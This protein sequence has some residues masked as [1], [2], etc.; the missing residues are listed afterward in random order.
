M[1]DTNITRAE[2]RERSSLVRV[3]RYDVH[4]DLSDARTAGSATFPSTSRVSFTAEPGASTWIDI[5]APSVRRAALNGVE[6]DPS[7]FTGT[8]LPLPALAADNEL[9][10]E[11]DCAYM[12]TGEGLHRFVDPVDGS[13]YLYSQFEVADARRMYACFDQPDLKGEFALTVTA[14]RG[15]QV[16]SNAPTP[17]PVDAGDDT[18]RW[19]FD[20]TPRLSPY[21][22][23]L[24]AGPYHVVRDEYVGPH[25]TY[26]LGVFCR[27]SLAQYLD[28]DEVLT[29]TKQGFEFFE[30]A[31]A[32]PYPFA[33][34]DQLFVPEFN[35]GAM[36]NAACVTI[37]EDYVFR[38]RVTHYSYEQRANTVLHEL[39]HMWFG[40]LVTMTWWDDLWLNESFAEW[41]AHYSSVGA[42][43]YRDAWTTFL[44]QRKGWAYKQ[45]QLSSTHPIAA[46]M[47]DLEA[48]EVNFDG[49][50]YAQGASALRQLVAWVGEKEFLE[51]LTAYFTRHAWGNTQLHDLLA[52]L[53]LSSGRDLSGWSSA[54]LETSGVNLLRPE[55]EVAADGT[56]S[57]FAVRQEPPSSPPGVTPVL[58][59][60]RIAIGLYTQTPN[61]LERTRRLEIDVVG[62]RTEVAELVGHPM[63]DLLLLNDDDLTFTK[64][65]LDE[66]SLRTAIESLET[67]G[68]PLPRALIWAAAWDMLRDAEMPMGDFLA[69]VESGL[70]SETDISVITTLCSQTKAAIEQF[71]G[72]GR[73]EGYRDRWAA[74]TLRLTESADPSSDR[75]LAFARAYAAACRTPEQA[76]V[77]R[78]WL[79]GDA[80]DGLAVDTDLRWTLLQR[81]LAL[82]AADPAEIDTELAADD[83]ATGRRQ[84]ATARAAVPTMA[85][86]EAAF[87]AAVESDELPNALLVATLVGFVQA[88]Q[89][90]LHRAFLPRYFAA[91]PEVWNTRT[92]ETA[93]TIVLGLYPATLVEQST[94]DLTDEFLARD[95]VPAGAR[96]LVR[97]GRDGIERSLRCQARDSA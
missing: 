27:A 84:A 81:L 58:R 38:S 21:I 70:G 68:E 60:H 29:V 66:R 10:V 7:T 47:V 77:V 95:D 83:T 14:P 33:K 28:A 90:E 87:A 97:E 57:S 56:L 86:K 53:E 82:G 2:A 65:R 67:L 42:T 12:R 19:S 64:I 96:R 91:L 63:P 94:L 71:S 79:S 78:R 45:A 36:E 1:T 31:F 49:I 4:V 40:D 93:Q 37:L 6:L 20:V 61:G 46:D 92:N 22:T 80:P 76:A 85:A 26:P 52:E 23:A 24:V 16:V 18:A 62:E 17:E 35:A 59:P 73:R 54:W 69:L 30:T 32:T 50:T 11:A 89:R 75:Q 88:D 48:V 34:Y 3:S 74:L 44:I 51:G 43:R 72:V 5:V 9:V 15:W 55:L 13:V 39:A 41:A 8:R 25:G